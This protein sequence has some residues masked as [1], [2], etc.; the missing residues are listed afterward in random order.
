M[1]ACFLSIANQKPVHIFTTFGELKMA[2]NTNQ[3]KRSG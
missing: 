2:L 3:T 1:V